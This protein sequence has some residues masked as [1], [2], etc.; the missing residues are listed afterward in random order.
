MGICPF[1][2][3]NDSCMPCFFAP[4]LKFVTEV[5]CKHQH[6]CMLPFLLLCSSPALAV[7]ARWETSR[8][9]VRV[10]GNLRVYAHSTHALFCACCPCSSFAHLHSAHEAVMGDE[11]RTSKSSRQP[12]SIRP[13]YSCNVLCMLPLLF[14]C[15]SPLSTRGCAGYEQRR[16][17]NSR[18]PEGIH[19]LLH[20]MSCACLLLLH[21]CSPPALA[22]G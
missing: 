12:E 20:E 3:C 15:S 14:L 4:A 21:L 9:G 1:L 7:T 17:E 18:Q 10:A 13:L 5:G 16:S 2:S 19:Q 6:L 22:A 8:G 11:Q